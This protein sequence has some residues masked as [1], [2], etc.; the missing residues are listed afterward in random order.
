MKRFWIYAIGISHTHESFYDDLHIAESFFK[1][2]KNKFSWAKIVDTLENEY[3]EICL[4]D[5]GEWE[6][7]EWICLSETNQDVHSARPE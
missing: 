7:G 5:S 3:I 1:D 4:N 2:K 6:E